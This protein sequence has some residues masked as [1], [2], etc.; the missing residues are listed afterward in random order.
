MVLLPQYKNISR[1]SMARS[2][3]V[4]AA[5]GLKHT[6]THSQPIEVT[7]SRTRQFQKYSLHQEN[8]NFLDFA[9]NALI[10]NQGD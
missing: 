8:L 7:S 4:T 6:E 1:L 5:L 2:E 3:H 10:Q 9:L